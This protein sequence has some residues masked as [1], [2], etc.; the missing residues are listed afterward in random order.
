VQV[1]WLN[2][3]EILNRLQSAV[4]ELTRRHP[5]I[6]QVVLFGSLARGEAVPGSDADLLL[7][8]R[9]SREPFLERSARY[10][11]AEVGIGLD[12]IVY[13]QQELAELQAQGNA[14]VAQAL[15]EG[16]VLFARRPGA[17]PPAPQPFSA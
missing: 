12:L 6:E 7:V 13:T 10:R 15:K 4:K 1:F 8:L 3:P 17:T 5:E 9:E 14:L 11:P 16:R 2:R